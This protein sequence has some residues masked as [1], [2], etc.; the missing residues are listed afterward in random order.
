MIHPKMKQNANY[1]KNTAIAINVKCKTKREVRSVLERTRGTV[2]NH[3]RCK[4]HLK[5]GTIF[6][7]KNNHNYSFN[8]II[9]TFRLRM[10]QE[11]QRKLEE[12]EVKTRELERRGVLV[13]KALRG[14]SGNSENNKDDTELLKEWFD[15]MR[16]RTE[17]R[18]Y[19][20][21]LSIRAQEL[22]L[23]DRHARLQKELR[24]RLENGI[25]KHNCFILKY[26]LHRFCR[27]NE[28]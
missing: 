3:L 12:I 2:A 6:K 18:R 15:L 27:W 5:R 16:D 8:E 28:N 9:F 25:K 24:E 23:E 17:L 10:A 21:E 7:K 11:I 4:L 13:E 19:E 26:H 22:E 1:W 20:K 14:E